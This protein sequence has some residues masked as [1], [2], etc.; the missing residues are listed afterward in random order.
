MVSARKLRHGRRVGGGL[1]DDILRRPALRCRNT[2]PR[3]LV[4]ALKVAGEEFLS[5]PEALTA[6]L[7]APCGS[8]GPSARRPAFLFLSFPSSVHYG[9]VR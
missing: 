1:A 2:S 8:D 6:L 4:E 3:R 5:R 9:T 7:N